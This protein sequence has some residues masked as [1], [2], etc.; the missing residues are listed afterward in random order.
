MLLF[1]ISAGLVVLYFIT[2]LFFI[3][4]WLKK[5]RP[6]KKCIGPVSVSVL[7]P[8]RDEEKNIAKLVR[9][10]HQ[11]KNNEAEFILIDDH[12]TDKSVQLAN[13]KIAELRDS[14]F[15]LISSPLHGKKNAIL[16][17]L[18]QASYNIIITTDAD[19]VH[20]P[21]WCSVLA[22]HMLAQG[23][24]L[25]FGPVIIT[26]E[27]GFI[28]HFDALDFMSLQG[29]GIAAA[30]AGAPFSC[31][32]AN[33]AYLKSEFLH[34][35]PYA[36]HHNLSGDDIS[37]LHAYKDS[38]LPVNPV[39]SNEIIVRT[40]PVKSLRSLVL[41]RMRWGQ[42][43]TGYHDALSVYLALLVFLNCAVLAVSLLYSLVDLIYFKYFLICWG[44]KSLIDFLFLFLVASNWGK[45]G[46]L[47]YFLPVALLHLFFIPGVAIAGVL[48]P[49]SWRGRKISV[50]SK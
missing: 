42:K 6:L 11:Q 43:A 21:D 1:F 4:G 50:G 3:S 29:A 19:C 31:S 47:W 32:G 33:L 5:D 2:I 17:G 39:N 9:S 25:I 26:S 28:G 14:R 30:K 22:H 35:Q 46:L 40:S 13:E 44:V 18:A 37:L 45:R 49:I 12:S 8:F 36:S 34:I 41:Q 7:V 48:I 23:S 27:K 20:S 10:L 24:G 15:K 16:E 38:G